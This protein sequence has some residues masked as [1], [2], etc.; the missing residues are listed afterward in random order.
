MCR[1]FKRPTGLQKEHECIGEVRHGVGHALE[2]SESIQG[3]LSGLGV[4]AGTALAKCVF[5]A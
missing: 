1:I 3:E 4:G 2:G 5:L